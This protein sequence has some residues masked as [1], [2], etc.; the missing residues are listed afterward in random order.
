[1]LD[2]L[3][4]GLIQKGSLAVE[5]PDGCQL[6]Y[7][8]TVTDPDRLL[9]L[10]LKDDKI[11]RKIAFDPD[12]GFGEAY[13]QG[14]I[15]FRN[16]R[17]YEFLDL[18]GQ[19][20]YHPT[21]SGR[22][23]GPSRLLGRLFRHLHQINPLTLS[24]QNVAHHYDLSSELYDL[25]LDTDRQYSC[26]Y[27]KQSQDSLS[28][29]QQQKKAHLIRKLYPK[30]GQR[31]LDIGC[32]WGGMAID[33]AKAI[34]NSHILGITLSTE[35]L[36]VARE[37]AKTAGLEARV[38][39][40]L[41]DYR[42]MSVKSDGQFDRIV[43]VGMFEHVGVPNYQTYFDKIRELLSDEGVA[44]LHA[45]GRSSPPG[46][47]SPFIR[48]YIFPGG[49][50]PALSEV[51]PVIENS[52][53]IISDVEILRLHYAETLR[54]WR[55]HFLQNWQKAEDLYDAAFCRMWEFYL[56]GSEMSFRHDQMMVFQ[57]QLCRSL[58]TLPM[59]RNYIY[60]ANP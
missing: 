58:T 25:F 42:H 1:M 19:N 31:I 29:A 48:K 43:S 49:Y 59:T 7:G 37:K 13:M 28:L 55:Y 30:A 12:P 17:V 38:Q 46:I 56:A 6:H 16:G 40:E 45:I 15:D 23:N 60:G 41:R 9:T 52:H 44:V 53:L 34:P 24:R 51:I 27:F 20:L 33:L 14:R 35:Q 4:T 22:P 36:K 11:A 10:I 54:Q 2:R 18:I 8:E 3:L 39:F 47:T 57:I 32:G 21:S 50:I 26:A 5:N